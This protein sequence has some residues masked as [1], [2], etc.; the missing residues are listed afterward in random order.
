[1]AR[2]QYIYFVRYNACQTLLGAFTVKYEAVAWAK[3]ESKQPLEHLQLS[4]MQDGLHNDKT[5]KP[6]S[7]K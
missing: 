1:M 2:S 3:S 7:W 4:R 5:E 6:I